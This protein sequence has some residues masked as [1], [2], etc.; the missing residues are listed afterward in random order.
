MH[1]YQYQQQG[2]LKVFS[3]RDNFAFIELWTQFET[4]FNRS[5]HSSLSIWNLIKLFYVLVNKYLQTSLIFHH[6]VNPLCHY[7]LIEQIS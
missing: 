6:F 2:F 3:S 1:G 4:N 7:P 5:C